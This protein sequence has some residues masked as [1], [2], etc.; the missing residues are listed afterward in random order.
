MKPV[1]EETSE[2]RKGGRDGRIEG[3][4]RGGRVNNMN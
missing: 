4:E 3:S 1:S 2:G